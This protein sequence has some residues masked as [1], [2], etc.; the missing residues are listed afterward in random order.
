MPRRQLKKAN[1]E[2]TKQKIEN[3]V[4]EKNRERDLTGNPRDIDKPT[5][6]NELRDGYRIIANRIEDSTPKKIISYT[7]H[8]K[9]SDLLRALQMA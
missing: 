1:W 5:I 3:D 6:D 4:V 8:P 7:P 2:L 9:E